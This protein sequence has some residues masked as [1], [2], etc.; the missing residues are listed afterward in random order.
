MVV[1]DNMI[2]S[3]VEDKGFDE[4]ADRL[5]LSRLEVEDAHVLGC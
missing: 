4:R 5:F 3:G 2:S 1:Q